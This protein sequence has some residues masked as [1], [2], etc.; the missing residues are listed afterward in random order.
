MNE[1]E[2]ILKPTILIVDDEPEL[3]ISLS[4]LLEDRFNVLTAANGRKALPIIKDVP[5]SLLVLDLR[6]PELGGVELIDCIRNINCNI[7]IIVLTGNPEY[8][9]SPSNQELRICVIR[10][11]IAVD[12]LIDKISEVLGIC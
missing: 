3:L 7:P 8:A 10:K 9:V 4:L 6:M 2:P 12:T 1:M 11:P 5:L